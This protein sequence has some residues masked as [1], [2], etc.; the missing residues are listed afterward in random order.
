M[1]ALTWFVIASC[2]AVSE[3]IAL[4]CCHCNT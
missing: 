4:N 1:T 3:Y 2:P